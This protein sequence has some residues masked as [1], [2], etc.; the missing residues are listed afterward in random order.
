MSDRVSPSVG[1][2]VDS[3]VDSFV[4]SHLIDSSLLTKGIILYG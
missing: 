2:R 4:D 3:P 1:F